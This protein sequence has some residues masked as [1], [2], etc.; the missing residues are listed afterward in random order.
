[1]NP[2][3]SHS[4]LQTRRNLIDRRA[5]KEVSFVENERAHV[6]LNSI[7]DAVLS[8][9]TSGRVTYL[10]LVAE[11]MT[12]WSREE[13][14]GHPLTDVF[15]NSDGGPHQPAGNPRAFGVRHH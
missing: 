4:A 14:S 13:A 10:N 15:E 9:D 11:R 2:L 12:G 7:G 3:N 8:I 6:T 5:L 1:M